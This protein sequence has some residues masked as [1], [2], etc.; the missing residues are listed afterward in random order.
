M[1]DACEIRWKYLALLRELPSHGQVSYLS[2]NLTKIT[3]PQI[4]SL[5]ITLDKTNPAI[6]RRVL[7]PASVKFFDLHHIIQISMGWKN[8]HLFEFHVGDYKIGYTEPTEG[9]EDVANAAEVMLDLLLMKEGF[10]FAYLYDFGDYWLHTVEV[11]KLLPKEEGKV[12]P[13]CTDGQLACPSEDSGGI[14]GFYGNLEILKDPKHPEY[15]DTK[16]W[17]GRGYDPGKFDI[18]KVN[19]TLPKFKSWMKH[20]ED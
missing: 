7:V 4:L 18:N 16:R 6:W 11:E 10:T 8:S 17:L 20:W 1:N 19:K 13:V 15:K 9:F 3:L 2:G 14:S 5:K 12:Y